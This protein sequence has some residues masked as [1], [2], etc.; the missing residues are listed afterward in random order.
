MRV[1]GGGGSWWWGIKKK[2]DFRFPCDFTYVTLNFLLGPRCVLICC[3][4]IITA[5]IQIGVC[6]LASCAWLLDLLLLGRSASPLWLSIFIL[7]T[8]ESMSGVQTL[9]GYD[10]V[11]PFRPLYTDDGKGNPYVS[12]IA[13]VCDD[14]VISIYC[15]SKSWQKINHSGW[16]S[17]GRPGWNLLHI[18]SFGSTLFLPSISLIVIA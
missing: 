7:S 8:W 12:D 17:E 1:V 10:I 18:I 3:S 14:A 6:R 4:A 13:C 9:L 5:F 11:V 16:L 2:K 15:E